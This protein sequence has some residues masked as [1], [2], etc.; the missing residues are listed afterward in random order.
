[1]KVLKQKAGA[2]STP[3]SGQNL[4]D[5]FES[6]TVSDLIQQLDALYDLEL[7]MDTNAQELISLDV[8]FIKAFVGKC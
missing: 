4:V 8:A 6:R 3:E 5:Y 2:V 1:M 7:A